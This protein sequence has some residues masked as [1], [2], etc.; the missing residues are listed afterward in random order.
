V[1]AAN[2]LPPENIVCLKIHGMEFL[3]PVRPGE[4]ACFEGKIVSAGRSSLIA[5]VRMTVKGRQILEGFITFIHVDANGNAI[6]HGLVIE[7]LTPEDQELQRRASL[8][9]SQTTV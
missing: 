9:K 8:L 1:A 7:P 6:P 3:H 4:I 2:V 5:F